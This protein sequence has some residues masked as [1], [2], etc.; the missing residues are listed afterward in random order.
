M[1]TH[2]TTQR[3]EVNPDTRHRG[4]GVRMFRPLRPHPPACWLGCTAQRN[5]GRKLGVLTHT[6]WEEP[7]KKNKKIG[8]KL[9]FSPRILH[10]CVTNPKCRPHLPD[11]AFLERS[12][13]KGKSLETPSVSAPWAGGLWRPLPQRGLEV[14]TLVGQEKDDQMTFPS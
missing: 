7:S 6:A 3:G 12:R 13:G 4:V 9:S 2:M 5:G 14:E 8:T 10:T 1:H 11:P